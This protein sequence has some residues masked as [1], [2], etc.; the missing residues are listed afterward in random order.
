VLLWP[1]LFVL[2]IEHEVEH[3]KYGAIETFVVENRAHG[4]VSGVKAIAIQRGQPPT[5]DLPTAKFQRSA[6]D[7]GLK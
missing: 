2:T 5:M 6:G 1:F 3:S 7:M 4:G